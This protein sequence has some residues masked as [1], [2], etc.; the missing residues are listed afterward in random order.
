VTSGRF[1]WRKLSPAKSADA[2]P[3]RLSAWAERLATTELRGAK[4]VRLEI[5]ALRRGEAQR[6]QREFGGS[7]APQ[8]HDWMTAPPIL[9]PPIRVRGKLVVVASPEQLRTER[10]P[11]ETLVIPAGMAF[12]TGDH[13]TTATCLRLLADCAAELTSASW[14]MLDLG[15]GSGILA[16]AARRLGAVKVEAGDFDPACVRIAKENAAAN[17]L[18]GVRVRRLDVLRWT[19]ERTWPV[20]TANLFSSLLIAIAP[21]LAKALAADGRLIFSGIL[22]E[23]EE[24]VTPALER[25]GLRIHRTVRKG[26]WVSGIAAHRNAGPRS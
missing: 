19:P 24:D 8:W 5:F 25:V 21:S 3:E 14:E 20:I 23:Q 12:G 22:R 7:I 13:A 1:V 15:C 9:R 16:L 4:T 26:K 6:L 18:R 17:G 10:S 2:W 11:A